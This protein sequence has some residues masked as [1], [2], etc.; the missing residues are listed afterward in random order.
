[1]TVAHSSWFKE[2]KHITKKR[3]I[4]LDSSNTSR[5]KNWPFKFWLWF[6][7]LLSYG[8]G[9]RAVNLMSSYPLK[10]SPSLSLSPSSH[11][12]SVPCL[13]HSVW[14]FPAAPAGPHPPQH[15]HGPRGRRMDGAGRVS[16]QE[17]P[18]SRYKPCQQT[19]LF[20]FRFLSYLKC[21]S[22]LYCKYEFSFP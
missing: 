21:F 6:L 14:G 1:M 20:P 2:A 12:V 5:S 19:C 11:L 8:L 16:G 22:V 9:L 3:N 15:C 17:W 7:W 13:L 10:S 18:L 4:P